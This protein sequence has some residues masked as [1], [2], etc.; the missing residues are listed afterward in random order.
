METKWKLFH[1]RPLLGA[2]VGAVLGTVVGTLYIS[3]WFAIVSACLLAALGV[4]VFHRRTGLGL[5]LILLAVLLIRTELVPHQR[6]E[7]GDYDVVGTVAE[8]PVNESWKTVVIL[9]DVSLNGERLD[10]RVRLTIPRYQLYYGDRIQVQ[11]SLRPSQPYSAST[12]NGIFSYGYASGQPVVLS[13]SEDAYGIL[14]RV[15]AYYAEMLD[16]LYG[17]EAPIAKA[18]LIG[19]RSDLDAEDLTRFSELGVMHIFAVSGMH[20]SALIAAVGLLFRRR[21]T[22]GHLLLT[23]I[24]S[25]LYCAL[26]S[27]TPA[28]LRAASFLF[29]M[30]LPDLVE[31]QNDPVSAFYGSVVFVLLVRPYSLFT[32]GFLLSFGAMAGL[33]LLEPSIRRR[34]PEKLS[35]WM[36]R[37]LISTIAVLVTTLPISAYFFGGFSWMMIPVTMILAP[38]LSALMPYA[39]LSLVLVPALPMLAKVLSIPAYGMFVFFDLLTDWV[40]GG[41]ITIPAPHIAVLPFWYGGIVFCSPLFLPNVK[42]RPWIGLALLIIALILWIVL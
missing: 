22:W 7:E 10:S 15:R 19:D 18:L 16:E 13:Q 6:V 14:I 11:A 30:R 37:A 20:V 32:A 17:R 35:S 40:Q 4:F 26:T 28:V 3:V 27:F 1:N 9:R 36:I 21:G 34:L 2:A 5:L 25:L 38:I 8:Q 12:S 41:I 42:H 23:A 24:V 39:F 31:R 33:L 29:L